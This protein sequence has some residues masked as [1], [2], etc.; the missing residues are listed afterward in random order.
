MQFDQLRLR[1][2]KFITLLAAAAWPLMAQ[3]QQPGKARIGVIG[4]RPFTVLTTATCMLVLLTTS[5]FAPAFADGQ[6]TA[7]TLAQQDDVVT[8]KA[9][10]T[11]EAVACDLSMNKALNLCMIRG[12]FNITRVSCDCSQKDI[13]GAP[14]WEC[15]GTAA[16]Q[17]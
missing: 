12:L 1:R 9:S 6:E 2:R 4:P 16:C 17:K 3:A 5:R 15:V 10:S 13:P 7:K 14:T 8:A 11:T